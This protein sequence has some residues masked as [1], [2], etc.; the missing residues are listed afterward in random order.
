MRRAH[1]SAR[2]NVRSHPR[3]PLLRASAWTAQLGYDDGRTASL[4]FVRKKELRRAPKV[5]TV[6]FPLIPY[7]ASETNLMRPLSLHTFR[8]MPPPPEQLETTRGWFIT[9]PQ[10]KSSAFA[11]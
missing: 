1:Q 10:L 9:G 8:N 4:K 11:N 3:A 2:A 5:S 7:G 6:S